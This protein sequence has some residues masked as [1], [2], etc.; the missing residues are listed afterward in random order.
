M[1]ARNRRRLI[2]KGPV[3]QEGIIRPYSRFFSVP[4]VTGGF[5]SSSTATTLSMTTGS[6][7]R[8]HTRQDDGWGRLRI[9]ERR[10]P[11]REGRTVATGRFD[12][13][14]EVIDAV[15]GPHDGGL[16]IERPPR[17]SESR[18]KVVSIGT[19]ERI[20]KTG[21]AGFMIGT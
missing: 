8:K 2:M 15:A 7:R 6:R 10:L 4:T 21:V 17:D 1:N 16:S 3:Q 5:F 12:R 9:G 13:R 20:G 14:C 18:R 11:D 19:H